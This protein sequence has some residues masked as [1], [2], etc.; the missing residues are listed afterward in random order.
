[1]KKLI[2]LAVLLATVTIPSVVFAHGGDSAQIHACVSKTDRVVKLSDADG[3]CPKGSTTLDWNLQGRQG[4]QGPA[5][6]DGVD[7]ADGAPGP[8]GLQGPQ[9]LPGLPGVTIQR[10]YNVE[11]SSDLDP[12]SA[13]ASASCE[14]GDWL[15]GGGYALG[16]AGLDS[17]IID[18]N[19]AGSTSSYMSPWPLTPESKV[20]TRINSWFV[21]ARRVDLTYSGEFLVVAEA[22]CL[23]VT[24]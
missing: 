8:Q 2:G 19:K 5:G 20:T 1:M 15:L 4:L 17:V 11:V 9:G 21:S 23:D 6:V 13:S 22:E 16:G 12:I 24:P 14:S 3:V 18:A 7:G 10:T